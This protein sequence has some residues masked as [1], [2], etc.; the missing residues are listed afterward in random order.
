M[1]GRAGRGSCCVISAERF[2]P[3]AH[4]NTPPVKGLPGESGSATAKLSGCQHRLH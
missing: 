1:A 4:P 2:V 3:S